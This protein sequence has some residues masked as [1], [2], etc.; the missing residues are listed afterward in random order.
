MHLDGVALD[1]LAGAFYLVGLF[2]AEF[3][4]GG[5]GRERDEEGGED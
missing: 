1:G 3:G 2:D 4:G 5:E